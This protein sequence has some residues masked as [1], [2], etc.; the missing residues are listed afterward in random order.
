[1][2]GECEASFKSTHGGSV[3]DLVAFPAKRDQVGFGVVTQGAA[4]SD[5]VNIEILGAST[6]LAAPTIT[7]QD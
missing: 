1:L 3:Q 4:S 6:F 7:F 2:I 5:V